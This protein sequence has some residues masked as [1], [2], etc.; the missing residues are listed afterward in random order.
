MLAERMSVKLMLIVLLL[1]TLP[2]CGTLYLTQA[3]RGQWDVMRRRQPIEEVVADRSTPA[4]VRERLAEVRRV[5]DFASSELALPDNAS[6]RSYADVKRRFVVWN[7]VAAPEF[8]VEPRR[9]CFPIVGCVAYRGYFT[10][11]RAQA[12]A[13]RLEARGFDVTVGGVPAYSTLGRTADP[14]LNTMLVYGKA[15]LAA[16]IFHELAHQVVYVA[17]DSDFN[18]AFA[19]TVE[20]AGLERWLKLRDREEELERYRS[21]QMRQ[22]EVIGLFLRRR[23]EL[24]RLYASRLVPAVMRKRK[25]AIFAALSSELRT[26][27]RGSGEPSIYSE[28]ISQG[29]NNAHLASVATYFACLPGFE[30][31]LAEEDGDLRAF[32]LKVRQIAGRPRAERHARLCAGDGR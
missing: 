5:R 26:M 14:V 13:A 12:F 15:E 23:A 4:D 27:T 22:H 17:G 3:A 16:M 7:V 19:M 29:L 10:E 6:Y 28:W 1:A 11:S 18:E 8:S 20:K 31:L 21:R 30:R 24:A 25:Q 32:Y 2:G 9:W